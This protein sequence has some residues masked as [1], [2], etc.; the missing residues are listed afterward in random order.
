MNIPE[1]GKVIVINAIAVKT[2]GGLQKTR[3]LLEVMSGDA[4]LKDRII[5]CVCSGTPLERECIRLGFRVRSVSASWPGRLLFEFSF[6]MKLPRNSICFNVGG[7]SMAG[8]VGRFVNISECA[9]SNLFFPAIKFWKWEGVKRRALK[10]VIDTIRIVMVGASDVII[11]QTE[12]IRNI[13]IEFGLVSP[14]NSYVVPPSPSVVID[15]KNVDLDYF[16]ALQKK[17]YGKFVL[18]FPCG[19]QKNKRVHVLPAIAKKLSEMSPPSSFLF[20]ITVEK[21][22]SFAM[23]IMETAKK[24]GVEDSLLFVGSHSNEKYS[25]LLKS[26]D[27][28]CNFAVLESFSNN[29]HE[30]WLFKK[31]LVATSAEWARAAA[32]RAAVYVDPEDAQLAANKIN[33]LITSSNLRDR[34]IDIGVQILSRYP[35][36][37]MKAKLYIDIIQSEPGK[38]SF[39]C[40]L[41]VVSRWLVRYWIG[42]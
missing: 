9:Y 34:K 4:N 37:E 36:P 19:E 12:L 20:V 15:P 17:F 22:S 1:N 21:T 38:R 40:K 8:S 41:K 13:S 3:S 25:A 18:L 2:G 23:S 33:D 29:F 24:Y 10:K 28:I 11:F 32:G 30:A 27:A 35:T 5:C 6:P 31:V 16:D 26:S 7:T 42:R 39:F 14:D